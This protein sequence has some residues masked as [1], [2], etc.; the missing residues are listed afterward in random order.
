MKKRIITIM[1][2]ALFLLILCILIIPERQNVE[3]RL[4]RANELRRVTAVEG[5][6]TK[7]EYVNEEGHITFAADLGY[8]VLTVT[9]TADGKLEEYFDENGSPITYK[10]NMYYAV[11]RKYDGN[12]NNTMTIFLDKN[13]APVTTKYGY[14]I[15]S[16]TFTENGLSAKE[17]YY[18]TEN[19]PVC[20]TV[21]GYARENEYDES[22]RLI[23][24]TFIDADGKPMVS[25]LGYAAIGYI[26]SNDEN[27][28]EYEFYFDTDGEPIQ[29]SLGQ[30]GIRKEY[31]ENGLGSVVTYLDAEG[32]PIATTK[33]YTTIKRTFHAD[34]TLA[35]EQYYDKDGNP[36]R[37]ADGQYGVKHENGK[38]AYLD[39]TGNKRFSLRMLLSNHVEIV[40][41]SALFVVVFSCCL[42]RKMNALLL[43]LYLLAMSYM[44]LMYRESG[45]SKYDFDL[46][47]SYRR[48]FSDV[49]VRRE[50]LNNILL[51]VPFGAILFRLYPKPVILFVPL[52]LSLIIEATQYLT[53]AGLC[54]LDDI[55][56]N[57][58][59][60]CI[61]FSLVRL[62]SWLST[63][64]RSQRSLHGY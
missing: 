45:S 31:D 43:I 60:G 53:G 64:I 9:D 21:F 17:T 30:C 48:L 58:L 38:T 52:L 22:G 51:F 15:S 47:W 46:F 29:L 2:I 13:G 40:I 61:G 44:T 3:T 49:S 6:T 25:G 32:N 55:I 16:R 41:L 42:S 4:M 33:G 36:Y 59:G 56:S 10:S 62:I 5:N 8:A 39:K 11:L 37:L 19:K 54:E 50:V 14:A 35:T 24:R 34:N 26:Y 57:T 7:T 20:T 1:L 63:R 28:S 12:G 18:D 23:R 27:K